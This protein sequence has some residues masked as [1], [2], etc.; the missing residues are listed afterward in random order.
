MQELM[1]QEAKSYLVRARTLRDALGIA[2]SVPVELFPFAQGEHNAN[3]SFC[4]PETGKRLLLRVNCASQL[5]LE[6]QIEYEFNVL[7]ELE[8]SGRTPRA[9]FVDDSKSLLDKGVLV[10][11]FCPGVYLD[12]ENP[13]DLKEVAAI[14]AD[15]HCVKP[16]PHS[17][18]LS[19][20]DALM[21]LYE[22]CE[23]MFW[24]YR[25]SALA[26]TFIVA[27]IESFFEAVQ[28]YIGT[29]PCES[30]C[31]HILNTEANSTHFL[32]PEDGSPGYMVDWDKPIR[33][34]AV[35]DVAYFMAPTTTIWDSDFIFDNAGREA[36]L[37]AYWHAVAGRFDPGCFEERLQ[38]FTVMNCLR[39]I[40]WC[41]MAWTRY[42]DPAYPLKNERT[43]KKLNTYLSPKFLTLLKRD[44][45]HC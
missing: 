24:V 3:F 25:T 4:H 39:G 23:R 30:D 1:L 19:P 37:K 32:L 15:L 9:L 6:N 42:H 16:A 45:F 18:L 5:G 11:E 44:Y 31:W 29:T 12:F 20:P 13:K 35:R 22:E 36:F 2:S 28:P 7:R 27:M 40:T 38:A 33:G 14:L 8:V 17:S 21:D 43:F 26:D 10:M 34:E 41:S